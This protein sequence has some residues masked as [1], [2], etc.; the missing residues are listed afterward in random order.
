M[1]PQPAVTVVHQSFGGLQGNR[2]LTLCVQG[3]CAPIITSS[4]NLAAQALRAAPIHRYSVIQQTRDT[5]RRLVVGGQGGN[6]THLNLVKSQVHSA[7]LSPIHLFGGEYG[8][9]TR[10]KE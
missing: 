3:R 9:R 2:T 4:P 7:G 6:R 5:A 8:N 10:L 1:S